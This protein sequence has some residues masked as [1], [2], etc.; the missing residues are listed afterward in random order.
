[1]PPDCKE[2]CWGWRLWQEHISVFPTCLNVGIFSVTRCVGITQQVSG[3]LSEGNFP[4]VA[5]YLVCPWVGGNSGTSYVAIL[6]WSPVM[7]YLI[8]ILKKKTKKSA[9]F[10][11]WFEMSP[12]VMYYICLCTGVCIW[13]FQ[14][15]NSTNTRLFKTRDFQFWCGS[16]LVTSVVWQFQEKLLIF[17]LSGFFLFQGWD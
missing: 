12:F 17:S 16:Y 11:H 2:L 7:C 6:V 13:I 3:F 1:M 5:L 10:P 14:F 15:A 4:C 8:M 9:P